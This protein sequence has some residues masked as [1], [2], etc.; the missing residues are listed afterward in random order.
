MVR[1]R[2]FFITAAAV[3]EVVALDNAFGGKQLDGAVD[4]R[5]RN[6][7]VDGMGAP[8]QLFDIGMIVGRRQDFAPLCGAGRSYA[9]RKFRA[10]RLDAIG[11]LCERRGHV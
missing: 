1:A 4:R 3:A 8:V 2:G 5:Q 6:L 11:I 10:A 7:G 9:N